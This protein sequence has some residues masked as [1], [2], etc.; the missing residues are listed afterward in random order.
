MPDPSFAEIQGILR[1]DAARIAA[2]PP[3]RVAILRNVVLES[4]EPYLRFFG[5]RAGLQVQCRFGDYDNVV[6]EAVGGRPD[7]LPPELDCVIVV[8]RLEQLAPDLARRFATL[9]AERV[10]G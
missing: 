10:S 2:L 9:S 6:P 8:Q 5:Y 3:V 1:A 7:L 4:I